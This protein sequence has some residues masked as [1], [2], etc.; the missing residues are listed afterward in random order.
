ME[1]VPIVKA[2]AVRPAIERARCAKLMIRR[3][4]PLA[5]GGGAVGIA[6]E[7]L[8]D[9]GRLLWPLAVVAW[10]SRRHL[11]DHSGVDGVVIAS[12]K[13]RGTARRAEGGGVKSVVAKPLVGQP[14]QRGCV[15]R[16]AEGARLAEAH[17]I[18]QNQQHVWRTHRRRW[19]G[20]VVRYGI[21]VRTA[22]APP[23][24]GIGEWQNIG[25]QSVL[26]AL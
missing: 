3:V 6:P 8:C 15:S 24:P 14:L 23:K 10:K 9:A 12:R 1:P 11:G 25:Q 4:V 18:K 16:P 17:V 5:E 20:N 2:L 26:S 7:N 19:Q 22:D 13:K 21:G